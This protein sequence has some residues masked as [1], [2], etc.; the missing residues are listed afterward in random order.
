MV[1]IAQKKRRQ[2]ARNRLDRQRA[3][4][5]APRRAPPKTSPASAST[6][7]IPARSTYQ[8][9]VTGLEW[10]ARLGQLQPEEVRAGE[11]YGRDYRFAAMEGGAQLRSSLDM[12]GREEAP[13]GGGGLPSVSDC[14]WM[15]AEAR[16]DLAR[17]HAA[18]GQHEGMILSCDLICGQHF[19]ARE[20]ASPQREA[21]QIVNSLRLAL[22]LL[23][24]HYGQCRK[25]NLEANA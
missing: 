18:L 17:A 1:S 6:R 13:A 8:R 16:I 22:Q 23:V 14:S 2:K 7:T 10:L 9:R 12:D 5:D 4:G 19:T 24:R 11:R 21:E 3:S 15:I 25:P 20:I